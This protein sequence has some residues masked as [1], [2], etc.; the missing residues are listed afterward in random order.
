MSFYQY[1]KLQ[2]IEP[3]DD[4]TISDL[5]RY[6][7]DDVIDLTQDE[8]GETLMR[9]IDEMAASMHSTTNDQ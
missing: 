1:L 7:E 8:D 2:P 4:G 9:Q 6:M 3:Q 5:D